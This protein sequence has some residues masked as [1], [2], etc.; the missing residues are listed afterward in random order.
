MYICTRLIKILFC[1]LAESKVPF[2]KF[3]SFFHNLSRVLYI[4]S[5]LKK[6]VLAS[7]DKTHHENLEKTLKY[8]NLIII[9]FDSILQD[10]FQISALRIFLYQTP[11]NLDYVKLFMLLKKHDIEDFTKNPKNIKNFK[12]SKE[13]IRKHTKQF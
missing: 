2:V 7:S 11:L 4:Q 10:L 13:E 5:D 6:I 8:R 12:N 9:H 1:D 3:L